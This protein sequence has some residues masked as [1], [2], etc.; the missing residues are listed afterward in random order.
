MSLSDRV[1]HFGIKYSFSNLIAKKSKLPLV[2]ER[3]HNKCEFEKIINENRKSFDVDSRLSSLLSAKKAIN[4]K[5]NFSFYGKCSICNKKVDFIVE[6]QWD[7]ST[8]GIYCPVCMCN[9]RLRNIYK[10]IHENYR[11]D[12]LVYISEQVTEFY[13][14]LKKRIPDVVGSE[15]TSDLPGV[16][17]EDVTA[18]SFEN[19]TFDMYISNDVFEHVFD[20]NAA[21]REAYRI[22]KIGGKLIFHVPFNFNNENTIIRATID[23]SNYINYIF[24]P[25]YHG[26]PID[27]GSSLFV[28]DFGFDMFSALKNAGFDDV[29]GILTND[30]NHGYINRWS[31]VFVSEKTKNIYDQKIDDGNIE[32]LCK[33]FPIKKKGELNSFCY[34]GIMDN[35]PNSFKEFLLQNNMPVKIKRLKDG[36]DERSLSI[37]DNTLR[38]ILH[39]PDYKYSTYMYYYDKEWRGKFETNFDKEYEEIYWNN[40]QNFKKNYP[41][42]KDDYDAEVFLY[43]HGLRFANEKIKRYILGKDFIDAGAYIGDSALVLFEYGP[44]K[45][46]SFEISDVSIEF[47]CKTMSLNKKQKDKYECIRAALSDGKDSFYV[48]DTGG[49]AVNI[50]NSDSEEN[51]VTSTDLDSFIKAKGINVGFIKA[52][53]EGAMYKALAGMEDTIRTFRPVLS[54]AI[55]HSPEEFFETKPLL[56]EITKDLNYKIEIDCHFSSPY[57]IYGTVIFAYPRELI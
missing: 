52:D 1:L 42:S 25:I 32:S 26:N 28:N 11:K 7:I 17:F 35:S 30:I 44:R 40:F 39:C 57:H 36:L 2:C 56:D 24:P 43:H 49:L 38:K 9:M 5:R 19:N 41:L 23:K 47:Y 12:M 13:K 4:Y 54:F 20:Y 18:L 6:N 31:I 22:L 27:D 8:E 14:L 21:F 50:F 15:Y 48:N 33:N 53:I 10:V 16:R 3:F 46:Y 45:I 37:V 51:T 34:K 55:Y 29:Y